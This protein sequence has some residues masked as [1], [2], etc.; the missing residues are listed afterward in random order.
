MHFNS[1]AFLIFLPVVI[2]LYYL[3][4]HR[5]RWLLLL[6]SSYFFYGFWKIEFLTL[7]VFSTVIDYSL[8]RRIALLEPGLKKKALLITSITANL[9]VLFLFKYLVLFLPSIE[10][11]HLNVFAAQNP[12]QGELLHV[13]YYS[14]PVGISFYTF[15]TMSYT[16]DVYFGRVKPADHLGKFAVF[17]SFFPQL[18]AGPIERYAH[19]NPQLKARHIPTYENF[20]NAFRLMLYGFFVKVCIADNLAPMVDQVFAAPGSF[21]NWNVIAGT[22]GFGFQIYADF[23]GYTLI[24]QGAA[25]CLGINLMDNFKTP[26]LSRSISEFWKRWHISLSTWFRDYLYIPLGG[27]RVAISRWS[28]NIFIVFVLSGFWHGAN[29]TFLIWGGIHGLIYLLERIVGR[30][31]NWSGSA[32]S[33]IRSLAGVKTFFFVTVAWVFFRIDKLEDAEIIFREALFG[34]GK[35]LLSLSPPIV[36]LITLFLISDIWLYNKRFDRAIS[37]WPM[38]ARWLLYASLLFAIL[39]LGGH[40]NHPFIYFQF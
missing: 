14:I 25:L 2:I 30:Y 38:A 18:V 32:S 8:S 10:M 7:I 33:F 3:I 16:I 35:E 5:F 34:N 27:N 19:L 21:S 23:A 22:V 24:A 40:I 17:V 26:Y 36:V 31:I 12:M 37:R 11:M 9:G 39:T 28:L 4:P 13:L 6:A 15:Q 29:W 1:V 20:S